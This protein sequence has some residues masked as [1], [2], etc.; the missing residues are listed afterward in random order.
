L[1][2]HKKHVVQ[3][4]VA[5][6][7]LEVSPAAKTATP[8]LSRLERLIQQCEDALAE[9]RAKRNL[10]GALR[11]IRELRPC[12]ELKYKLESEERKHRGLPEDRPEQ[13]SRASHGPQLSREE[14]FENLR[15]VTLRLDIKVAQRS[16]GEQ[17]ITGE[18]TNLDY[19][20]EKY[21][22]LSARLEQRELLRK[23]ESL[24]GILTC[25]DRDA[26]SKRPHS[27]F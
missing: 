7:S 25:D 27:T 15:V 22:A 24:A 10:S 17:P 19:L 18:P 11:A 26:P 5:A 6:G 23:S 2:R 16:L 12:Y 3:L 1:D 4:D 14:I 8:L 21:A 9:A 20:Q 13:M